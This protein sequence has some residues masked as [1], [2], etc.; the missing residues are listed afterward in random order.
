MLLVY[1]HRW[2]QHGLLPGPEP[3]LLVSTKEGGVF[4]RDSSQ[5]DGRRDR[6]AHA[7]PVPITTEAVGGSPHRYIYIHH[8]TVFA[9][10]YADRPRSFILH[11]LAA[12]A[13][14]QRGKGV[15]L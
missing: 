14:G 9:V 3:V 13:F 4:G 7:R 6:I 5:P 8:A 12:A 10:A 1:G 2:D 15:A 11:G